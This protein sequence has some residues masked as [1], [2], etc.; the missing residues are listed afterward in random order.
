M[1]PTPTCLWCP[2]SGLV[3]IKQDLP[4]VS[5]AVRPGLRVT[6][7]QIMGEVFCDSGVWKICF[8]LVPVTQKAPSHDPW[9]ESNCVNAQARLVCLTQS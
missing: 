5:Q 7:R 8:V 9:A 1:Q 6:G 3:V 2:D 4:V